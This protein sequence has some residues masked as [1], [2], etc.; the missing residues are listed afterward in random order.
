VGSAAGEPP[1]E[2]QTKPAAFAFEDTILAV[3]DP[4]DRG[5]VTPLIPDEHNVGSGRGDFFDFSRRLQQLAGEFI[6]IRVR[7]TNGEERNLIVPP[8]FHRTLGV[9]VRMTMGEIAAIRENSPAQEAGLEKGNILQQVVLT[10]AKGERMRF[11][12]AHKKDETREDLDRF[13]DP[14]RLPYELRRWARAPGRTGV[15]ATLTVFRVN[16][17]TREERGKPQDLPA[18][19]WDGSDRWVYDRERPMGVNSPLAIPELG[20][21][22]RV[23]TTVEKGQAGSSGDQL[24]DDDVI[25]QIRFQRTA[26]KPGQVEDGKWEKVEHDQWAHLAYLLQANDFHEIAL[27]VER[28]KKGDAAKKPGELET[29]ELKLTAKPDETWPLPERGFLLDSDTFIVRADSF[30][31][32]VLMGLHDTHEQI[33]DVLYNIK[34]MFAQRIS[35]KNMGGPIMIVAVAYRV[36]SVDFWE[37]VF[38]LGMISVNLAVLNF[39]PIPVLDGGHMVFL[40]YEKLRGRPATEQVRTAAMFVGLLLIGSLMFFVFYLDIFTRGWF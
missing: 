14:L 12:T 39:L 18:V 40:I 16:P 31:Q 35:A 27:R 24:E 17:A 11:V 15:Q 30:G 36:A 25:T 7:G 22:Y 21:A 2:I 33:V 19:A 8:A 13:V 5:R 23:E 26:G 1:V 29:K 3:T 6:T 28:K 37:F 38:F 10:D 9:D 34:N 32:A 4:A 20:L